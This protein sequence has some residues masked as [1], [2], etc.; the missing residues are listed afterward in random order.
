M[1]PAEGFRAPVLLVPQPRED[2]VLR[3]ENKRSEEDRAENIRRAAE[4]A[5]LMVDAGLLVLC[6]FI[7]PY[8]SDRQMAH[9]IIGAENFVEV[10][11]DTP[12]AECVRRDPK[13]LYARAQ[14]GEISNLTGHSAPYE[15]PTSPDL[16]IQ[17]LQTS[18]E[19]AATVVLEYLVEHQYI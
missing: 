17:T 11:V 4:V 18:P 10:F 6:C 3:C 2:A 5:K 13:G 19:S 9:D 1:P 7:T 15:V 8:A 16:K 14:Q 12:I